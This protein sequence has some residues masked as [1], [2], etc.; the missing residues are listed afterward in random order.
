MVNTKANQNIYDY[1][2]IIVISR[3]LKKK[4]QN[5]II[6]YIHFVI[7]KVILH[8]SLYG[9]ILIN[10]NVR[11]GIKTCKLLIHIDNQ[12]LVISTKEEK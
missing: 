3:W 12:D 6:I 10:I 11:K 1:K 5:K 8:V 2:F 7:Y 9:Y 4:G